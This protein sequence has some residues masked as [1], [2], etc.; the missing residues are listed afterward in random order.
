M[1]HTQAVRRAR[2]VKTPTVLQM[3]AVECGAAALAIVL[4]HHGRIVPLEELRLACGVSRDGSRAS[5]VLKAARTYGLVGKGLSTEPDVLSSL[6]LPAIVFW[7]F[8]HFL[9]VEGFAN[10]RVYLN[11]PAYGPRVVS[12]REFDESFTGVV[13]VLEPGPQFKKGGVRR[14]LLGPLGR[15]LGG[16]WPALAFMLLASLALAILGIVIPTFT[17][18]FVDYVLLER[19]SGW[20]RP[21]L[22]AMAVAAL[23]RAALTWL[24]QYYLLRLENGLSLST[25]YRFFAHLLRLPLEFFSQRYCGEI[26]ARVE[27]NDHI[28]RLLS[29]DLATH[30]LNAFMAVFFVAVMLHYDVLLTLVGLA[31]V[32]LNVVA[33]R[34]VARRRIDVNQRLL[35]ERGKLL[36]AS[37]VGLQMIE[38]LKASAS[39]S[40]FFARWSGFFARVLTAEQQLGCYDLVLAS[41][42]PFLQALNTVAILG[43][44]SLRVMD[45]HMTLGMLAAFQSL[46]LS[47]LTPVNA[48]VALGSTLQE[49]EGEMNRLDDV[50][51]YPAELHANTKELPP[52]PVGR[53]SGQVELRNVTFGYS[54]LERPLIEN[55]SLTMQPGARVAL[56]GSSG[57]GK[58][59][60]ARLVSGLY[61]P[62]SGDILLDGQPRRLLPRAVIASSVAMVDQEI[63]LIEG[64]V[65]EALTL[66]DTTIPEEDVIQAARD[67]LIHDLIAARPGGYESRV[68]E[69]GRSFSGGERQRLEIARALAARP[70]LLILDEATSALDPVVEKRIDDN[71]RRRGCTC[72]I[73]AH[74]LSTIRDCDEIIVLERGAIVQR[75]TH[76]QLLAVPGPYRQLIEA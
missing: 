40:D 27:I 74:R 22:I 51:R 45:G 9:V 70:S 36:G 49:V 30:V 76:D 64:S 29:G 13:L 4:A 21:L 54:R 28:A 3:E 43:V 12:S 25:S 66:W 55:L 52:F 53:L 19:L 75:G 41:V 24:Q 71:L 32:A 31:I 7:N 17:R 8:H 18:I 23:L 68:E 11:D 57:S 65:R 67:A 14:G 37:M 50:Q 47:F 46:M 20:L 56:V 42:S 15:R 1:E 72:L 39:E 5:N 60:V 38:T 44:G 33:L 59:T 34:C 26:G 2:R 35:Q 63:F 62:W 58:S 48:L 16:A 6:P 10:G 73:V 61:Q 69:G